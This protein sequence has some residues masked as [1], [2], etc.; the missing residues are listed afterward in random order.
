MD[1]NRGY[2]AA[3]ICIDLLGVA[4]FLNMAVMSTA[5]EIEG[6]PLLHGIE[7]DGN[8]IECLVDAA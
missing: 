1:N 6:F 7:T 2:E 8:E 3:R 4:L 5:P